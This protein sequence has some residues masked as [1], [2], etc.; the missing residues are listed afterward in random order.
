MKKVN[1]ANIA[2]ELLGNSLYCEFIKEI[3]KDHDNIDLVDF[4]K[5]VLD[6]SCFL[7]VTIG[8]SKKIKLDNVKFCIGDKLIEI[9]C[10]ELVEKYIKYINEIEKAISVPFKDMI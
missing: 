5:E 6:K 4:G 8:M 10:K 1:Y 3:S 2:K 9:S 7:I